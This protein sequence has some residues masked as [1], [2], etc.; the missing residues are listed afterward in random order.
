[1]KAP[2]LLLLTLVIAACGGAD[3]PQAAAAADNGDAE[4]TFCSCTNEPIRTSAKANA[5]AALMEAVGPAEA[6]SKA[7]ACREQLPVPAGGP[8]RCFC[9]RTA[10]QD[11]ALQEACKAILPEDLTPRQMRDLIVECSR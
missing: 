11:P 3:D 7:I 2:T 4:V 1:M 9:L 8:D 6:A 10:T 5:C